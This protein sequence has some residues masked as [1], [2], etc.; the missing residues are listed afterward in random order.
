ML[1]YLLDTNINSCRPLLGQLAKPTTGV[2]ELVESPVLVSFGYWGRQ[3]CSHG[4]RFYMRTFTVRAAC[5]G[6]AGQLQ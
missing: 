4:R 2:G 1:R 6:T 3:V 5:W